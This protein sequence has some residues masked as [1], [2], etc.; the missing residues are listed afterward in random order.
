METANVDAKAGQRILLVA[1]TVLFGLRTS[2][3]HGLVVRLAEEG[4]DSVHTGD[5]RAGWRPPMIPEVPEPF[6]ALARGRQGCV[7][8]SDRLMLC[9]LASWIMGRGEL[10]RRGGQTR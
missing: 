1:V 8:G 3:V 10:E 7:F 6:P 9:E 4:V 2:R 5:S